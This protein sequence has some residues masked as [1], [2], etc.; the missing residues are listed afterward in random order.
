MIISFGWTTPALLAGQKTVTRRDW[1]PKHAAKFKDGML[2]DAWNTSPRNVHMSPRKV[3]VIRLTDTPELQLTCRTADV[4][5]FAEGFQYL[6]E[7]GLKVGK[8]TP[9]ELWEKWHKHTDRWLY[10]VR[11]EV[12]EFLEAQHHIAIATGME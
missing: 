4:D 7:H 6:S 3:A 1:S 8:E 12:V 9:R 2:V 11:F 5:W 10:V